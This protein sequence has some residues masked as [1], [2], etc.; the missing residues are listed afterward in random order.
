MMHDQK[1]IKLRILCS[2]IPPRKPCRLWNNVEKYG[3][4]GQATDGNTIRHMRFACWINKATETHSEYVIVN[5]FST[6]LMV[7]QMRLSI[8]LYAR[9]LPVLL[10]RTSTNYQERHELQR[11][12]IVC[13][14]ATIPVS[15]HRA[16]LFTLYRLICLCTAVDKQ[17]LRVFQ[18]ECC[19]ESCKD[20]LVLEILRGL[21]QGSFRLTYYLGNLL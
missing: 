18:T 13:E 10:I 5:C 2:I 19:H 8:T 1:T 11:W 4:A 12:L 7:A 14:H 16:V 3:R 15:A 6:C 9:C 20:V 21:N 17:V